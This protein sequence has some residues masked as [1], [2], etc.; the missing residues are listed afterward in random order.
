MR[1]GPFLHTLL[2]V[3]GLVLAACGARTTEPEEPRDQVHDEEPTGGAVGGGGEP[4][5]PP[6]D[7]AQ[8]A[9]DEQGAAAGTTGGQACTTSADCAQGEQ[10]FGPEGCGVQWTCV[11]ARA[12]T[13]DLAQYCGC[14]GLTVEGSGSCPPRAYS[15]RGP[16]P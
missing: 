11:A 7:D 12:C 2:L 13:R 9:G 14:D 8:W 1:T 3:V 6:G 16:C 10:C 4:A 5:P 15:H